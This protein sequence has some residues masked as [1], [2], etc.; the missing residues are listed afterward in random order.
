[1]FEKPLQTRLNNI[2]YH[3]GLNKVWQIYHMSHDFRYL[4]IFVYHSVMKN[5]DQ[6][7]TVSVVNFEK[8]MEYMA[9]EFH[10]HQAQGKLKAL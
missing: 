9:A 4:S 10:T 3:S 5:P 8:Q 6:G 2:F 7:F 1:M